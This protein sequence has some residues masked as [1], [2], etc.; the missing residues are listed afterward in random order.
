MSL[1]SSIISNPYLYELIR[2]KGGAYGAGMIID[3][4]A[5]FSTYSY[6]DPNIEKTLENYDKISEIARKLDMNER[7]FAN[8]KISTMGKF[9]RP[10]SPSQKADSDF[11]NYKKENPK[12]E[13]EILKEIKAADLSDVRDLADV[14]DKALAY[15]NILVFGNR[16]KILEKKDFFDKIIDLSD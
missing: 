16:E 14:L 12:N 8:Q 3:R 13:E 4:S 10:K 9:L 1:A 7:D 5:L 6:R 15:N 11:L 2:A